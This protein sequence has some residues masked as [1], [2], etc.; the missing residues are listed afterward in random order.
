[1]AG[2]SSELDRLRLQA[3]TWE[4]AGR[5]LLECLGAG[6]GRRALDVGCGALGWLRLLAEWVGPEGQAV[7][8][9]IDERLLGL[10]AE[11]LRAA[12]H[13]PVTLR[14]DDLF[15]SR[16]PPASFDLVHAR[17]Q[18]APIGREAEQLA[19][20]RRW[21]APGG[22]LVLEEPD[23]SSWHFNPP[24]PAAEAL[25]AHVLEAFR[26]GG[27]DFDAGRRLPELLRGLSLEP[28]VRAEVLALA[29]GHP[30]LRLPLQFAASLR[31]R[32]SSFLAEDEL[33]ALVDRAGRELDDPH[34]WG[35]SFT[36]VQ[37]W[38]RLPTAATGPATD[39]AT[40]PAGS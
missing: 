16:L 25:I 40:D 31:P 18:L 13:A 9:D 4:P 22:L 24:A 32:L 20:F 39:P 34:R 28:Q 7:G 36:L 15:A 37:A 23:A 35:T 5:R 10:A 33:A 12:G 27:G 26:R 29:P 17:F 1:M 30:Y 8:T 11:G 3:L 38:A 19:A 2:Q 21:L 14:A 6:R